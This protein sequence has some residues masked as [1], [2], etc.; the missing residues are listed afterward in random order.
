M[1]EDIK[2]FIDW[3]LASAGLAGLIWGIFT[4]KAAQATKRADT[5]LPLIE[6]FDDNKSEMFVA[7]EILDDKTIKANALDDKT[8]DPTEYDIG[9]LDVYVLRYDDDQHTFTTSEEKIRKSF[10]SLL[11]FFC[12]LDYLLETKILRKHEIRYFDY[13][14]N[15]VVKINA[16]VNYAKAYQ[17]PLHG[18]LHDRLDVED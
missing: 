18:N 2:P 7:K 5:L 6:E 9:N 8:D 3:I 15:R 10:D 14:I 17:F 13:Y 11:D 16:V 12:K 1:V 4:Y